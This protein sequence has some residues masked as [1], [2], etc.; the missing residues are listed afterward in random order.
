MYHHSYKIDK[1]YHI[2]LHMRKK[3]PHSEKERHRCGHPN[4]LSQLCARGLQKGKFVPKNGLYAIQNTKI[5]R[6]CGV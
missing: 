5:G 6:R 1:L 2:V 4:N 3:I